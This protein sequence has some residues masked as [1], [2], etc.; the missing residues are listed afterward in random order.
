VL[1]AVNCEGL[2]LYNVALNR[3]AYQSS[4]FR[5]SHGKYLAGLAND[6][7]RR[8][9]VVNVDNGTAQCS[10][11]VA[12]TNPW[13]TVDIGRPTTV[14]VVNLI[15]VQDADKGNSVHQRWKWVIVRDP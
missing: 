1:S 7:N 5:D 4:V 9:A 3:P 14:V 2:A 13:W 12:G 15:N 10:R 11:S 8:T 6:G